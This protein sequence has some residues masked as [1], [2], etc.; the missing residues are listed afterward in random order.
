[1]GEEN[2]P[3]FEP[4]FNRAVKVRSRDERLTSDAGVILVREA[5]HRLGLTES[6]AS[7]LSDP[8]HR[9]KI[10][11]K[12]IEL[13]RER[14]FAQVMGYTPADD[15]DRLAHDPALRLAAWDRPGDG[16]LEERLAS[17][18]TQS[19]LLRIF[20]RSRSNREALRSA[21]PE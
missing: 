6:L 11:Y 20:T 9:G 14:I 4:S 3:F 15:L 18:P 5:D 17:Q 21:L 1:M 2:S 16:V 10:R 12:L 8:R 13:L 7:Q 19:R